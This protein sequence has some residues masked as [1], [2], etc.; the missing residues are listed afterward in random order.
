M[1][2]T[3]GPS[4][5]SLETETSQLTEVLEPGAQRPEKL[6]G[7]AQAKEGQPTA[8]QTVQAGAD[9]TISAGKVGTI[10]APEQ[11]TKATRTLQITCP[12][13]LRTPTPH[14]KCSPFEITFLSATTCTEE[15]GSLASQ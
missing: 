2:C 8:T 9:L 10:R 3:A 7:L 12:G 1:G 15:V 5:Q 6:K 14:S 11:S 4:L 13:T